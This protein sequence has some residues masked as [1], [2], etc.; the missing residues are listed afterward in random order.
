MSGHAFDSELSIDVAL[1]TFAS[2]RIMME[3]DFVANVIAP[4]VGVP[5]KDGTYFVFLPI[6]GKKTSHETRIPKGGVATEFNKRVSKDFFSTDRYGKRELLEDDDEIA[7]DIVA[8]DYIKDFSIML[9]ELAC[10][11]ELAVAELVL[12]TTGGEFGHG[13][14]FNA[15]HIIALTTPWDADDSN[16]KEDIDAAVRQLRLSSGYQPNM[17]IVPN[18][19]YNA[20]TSNADLKDLIKYMGGLNYIRTGKIPD[21]ILYKLKVIEAGAIHDPNGTLQAENLQFIWENASDALGDNW[22]IVC[23]VDPIP[24]VRTGSFVSQFVFRPSALAGAATDPL[25]GMVRSRVYREEAVEGTWYE[26]R[27][28]YGLKVTNPRAGVLLTGV[29]TEES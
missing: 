18:N 24:S 7:G 4:P 13:A 9:N 1:T 26:A 27:T 10:E 21:D 5:K 19:A 8:V 28:N 16:P 6:E 12:A 11:R 22:A 23:F 20:L 2:Q 17:L 14:Y 29:I 25:F 15:N 3:P